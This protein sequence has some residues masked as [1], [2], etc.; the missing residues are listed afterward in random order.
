MA[1]KYEYESECCK[2]YYVEMRKAN[3]DQV[4]TICNNCGQG[5]YALIGQTEFED[6]VEPVY[7]ATE[8][9]TDSIEE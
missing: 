1:I 3:H 4:I 7:Q 8:A 5:K 2:H 9:S 6:V